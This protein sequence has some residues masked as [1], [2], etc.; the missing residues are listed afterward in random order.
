VL[1]VEPAEDCHRLTGI[2][3]LCQ[4]RL[5]DARHPSQDRQCGLGVSDV[6]PKGLRLDAD[7]WA[8]PI[9]TRINIASALHADLFVSPY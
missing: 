4:R 5:I 2:D 8:T 1:P 7:S 6:A 3:Q 9:A